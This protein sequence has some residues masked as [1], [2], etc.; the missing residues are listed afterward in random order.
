M[1][2]PAAVVT[3]APSLAGADRPPLLAEIARVAATQSGCVSRAD[4]LALGAT[5]HQVRSLERRG[6]LSR[7]FRGIY[8]FAAPALSQESLWWAC[9][10]LGGRGA[11]LGYRSAL[12]SRDVLTPSPTEV[13]VVVPRPNGG[14]RTRVNTLIGV[15]GAG[16]AAV[17]LIPTRSRQTAHRLASGLWADAVSLAIVQLASTGDVRDVRRAWR[18][19]DYLGLLEESDLRTALAG[20]AGS[21]AVIRELLRQQPLVGGTGVDLRSRA[22]RRLLEALTAAGV[23]DPRVNALVDFGGQLLRPDLWWPLARLVVEVDGP[24]H[25]RPAR[26][27]EDAARDEFLAGQGVRVLRFTDDRVWRDTARVVAEIIAALA[28]SHG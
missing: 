1:Q 27:A 21:P 6:A 4:L 9:L 25:R 19:A 7:I 5:R 2:A 12:E 22:E 18:E 16:P 13:T 20:H 26:A 10:L 17:N 24:G 28:V 15:A 8:L 3:N 23:A 14:K 11:R